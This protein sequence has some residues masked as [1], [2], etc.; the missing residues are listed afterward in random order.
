MFSG[1]LGTEGCGH[2]LC[3]T[4]PL[5]S[6]GGQ[7]LVQQLLCVQHKADSKGLEP[8]LWPL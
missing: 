8:G 3:H 5:P 4:V 2:T 1:R 7:S 6:L